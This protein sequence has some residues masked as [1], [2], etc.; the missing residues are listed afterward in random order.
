ML[1]VQHRK[2][3][4][5]NRVYQEGKALYLEQESGLIR[6]LPQTDRIIRVS[7][8]E[9]DGFASEQGAQLADLSLDG[10]SF[11]SW[12]EEE[13][14]IRVD[15]GYL[16]V[17][18]ARG[19]G[20]ISYERADGSLLLAERDRESKC[21]EAFDSYRMVVNENTQIE[22]IQTP[23]GIKRRIREADRVFDKKL[24]HTR[25]HLDFAPEEH[26]YGLGQAEEG[27][28]NLRHTTQYLHQANLKIAVPMLL[29]DKGY[30]I[31]LST[32]SPAIFNDTQYG[33]Y[34][35]T[36]ADE[37][38]DYYFLAGECADEVTGGFRLLT[39]KA[40]MLPRWA[41]G[42]I[43]SQERYESAVELVETAKRF[44]QEEIPLDALV[45]DWM[46]WKGNLW[47]QKTFDGER[48]PDP[49]DMIQ[50]LHEQKVHFM[51][52]I[53][54]NMSELSDNYQEFLEKG[55]LLPASEIY[56]AFSG[57]GR[58]LYWE[59][60]ERGLFRHGVDAW[61]C[62]SSEPVTPEWGRRC[63]PEPGEM[64]REFVEAAGSC[65]PLQK[66]NAYGLYHARA[67][68]EGQR[69]CT[70][71]KRVVNLTRNGY[72][73]SQ[74]YGTIL[75]SGDTYAS[76]DTLK[77]QIAAGLHFCASGLPY[78]TLDI[79]AFFVK[80]G[81][82]WFWNG[83]YEEGCA[84]PGYRELYVRWFQYGAFLPIFRSHGTD[85]RREPWNFGKKGEPFY[86]AILASIHLRYRLL[87]YIYSL[88]G[89]VWREDGTMMRLLA[90]D[91]PQDE[92]ALDIADEYMF[93]PSLLVCPVTQPMYYEAGGAV[94]DKTEKS[95][96]VYL[97]AGTSWYD[98][99]NGKKYEGG[100]TITAAADLDSI[101]VFVKA[102]SI[103]PLAKPGSSTADMQEEILLQAY[104]GA[105]GSFTLYEDAG[106]GYGYEKGEYCVTQITYCDKERKVEWKTE[107]RTEFRR[108]EFR[109]EI[110]G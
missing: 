26:L 100:Q 11:W 97:P 60:A 75:W 98:L 72:A 2:G 108:G 15:T 16:R 79:G 93:G 89:Q 88:A 109:V 69:S 51:I 40:A 65:M 21:V 83:D 19:T 14:E 30:G 31:L 5:I 37:Y 73:G 70:E 59:Q 80:K 6:I 36:E 105:D 87:P 22:E 76:W 81:E 64:Y 54:P 58:R 57:E 47:G 55:L 39:G 90:F 25:L 10:G 50:K 17:R 107:G 4:K 18:I 24:Y 23:D 67:L 86:D 62:D 102:G 46:S 96:E 8:T 61:W 35:Y 66:S 49:A 53:W 101:P 38:L 78:W 82:P 32:Q 7:Y 48:F 52:S 12:K 94:L 1:E 106:D 29:S 84:D 3:R 56:D 95:R 91:F 103:L 41:F 92:R 71:E 34:L 110:V 68:Y 20:S 44:R 77:K 45:L 63:K 28:W 9:N 27:V 43:Q 74:K 104:A 13:K 33:T 99:R 85:C 42:Y